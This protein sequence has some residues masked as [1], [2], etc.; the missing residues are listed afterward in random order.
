[1]SYTGQ[2][3][4]YQHRQRIKVCHFLKF[5]IKFYI[6]LVTLHS[7]Y[8][9]LSHAYFPVHVQAVRSLSD[10]IRTGQIR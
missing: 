8:R 9:D 10:R 4:N 3:F 6:R 7:S 5:N 1:M 2:L